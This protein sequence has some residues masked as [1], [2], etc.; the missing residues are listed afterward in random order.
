MKLV[1]LE[2]IVAAG[3]S[4]TVE[5]KKSTAQLTRVGQTLSAFLN[6]Q[7]GRVFIGVS[8]EGKVVG[9]QVADSTLREVAAMLARFEPAALISQERVR[10]PN[11]SEDL[12][13]EHSSHPRNPFITEVFY[14]RG[15]IEQWGR[16]TNKIIAL[17]V[18]AGL[19]KPEFGQQ[20]G[21]L[22]VRFR[23]AAGALTPEVTR[24][25]TREVTGEVAAQVAAQVTAEPNILGGKALDDIA[26]MLRL[27]AA[28]VTAQVTAQVVQ[29]L[30]AAASNARTRAE[31]QSAAGIKHREH[32]RKAYTEPM[33]SAGWLEQ[34]VPDKPRSRLQKYRLTDKGRAWLSAHTSGAGSSVASA[35]SAVKTTS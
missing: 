20:A 1:D 22:F 23:P 2:K 26:S 12:T 29:V 15:L 7:G 24:E 13:S 28:Q 25:V 35:K 21:S 18:K 19:P 31:L 4:E 8:P 32:F 11:G 5:F 14:R 3:E 10:L 6:G 33:V 17:C 9:Q 30:C 34:T 27:P 16:G